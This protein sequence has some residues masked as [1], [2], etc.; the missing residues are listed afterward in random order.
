MQHLVSLPFVQRK[1]VAFRWLQQLC[2][3][4]WLVPA[5]QLVLGLP[6]SASCMHVFLPEEL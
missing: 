5:C 4:T 6:S 3:G 1:E 2:V